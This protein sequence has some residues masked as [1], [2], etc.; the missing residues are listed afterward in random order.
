[1]YRFQ[2]TAPT[3]V[4]E[5]IALVGST[6]ALGQ[7]DITRCVRLQTDGDRYPLWWTELAIT[8]SPLKE[9]KIEYKYLRLNLYGEVEWE[10]G[11]HNRWIPQEYP[12]QF[13]AIIIVDDGDFGNPQPYPYGYFDKPIAKS[14]PTQ[15]TS[16]PKVMVV[17]S[18][19]AL[20]CSSWLLKGWTSRL[21]TV[22][23]DRYQ[24]V[25]CSFLGADVTSII[26]K[27]PRLIS[28][29]QPDIVIISL[30]LGNEGLAHCPR[31]QQQALR[32]RFETGLQELISMTRALGAYPILGG[33]YPHGEYN[34]EHY[35]VLQQTRAEMFTWGV[36]VIDWFPL[37]H[38]GI[39][40]W[41]KG[42]YFDPAHPN[43]EGHRLM[44]EA[45]NLSLFDLN[46]PQI[47]QQAIAPPISEITIPIEDENLSLSID[48]NQQRVRFTN[49]G[50][51][52]YTITPTWEALQ[53]K[54]RNR[55]ILKHSIYLEKSKGPTQW[56]FFSI[57]QEG[58][59]ETPLEI[60]PGN[61]LEYIEVSQFLKVNS[62]PIIFENEDL[63]IFKANTQLVGIIN[64]SYHTY[65]IHPM[66]QEVRSALKS[67]NEGVYQDPIDPHT[68]FRTMMIGAHGLE[69]RV[70]V[71]G[72]TVVYFQYQ[73]QLEQVQRVGIIPLGDRCAVRM[74]LYKLEYDGPAFPFDL[75]RTT[76][77]ADV[78]DIIAN[79][80]QDMWNPHFL[81]YNHDEKRIYH[82]RWSGLSFAHEVED[83]DNPLHD[84][85]PI[86]ARM[87]TRYSARSERFWYA[88]DKSDQLLFV[89]TG[90]FTPPK[91]TDLVS[92]LATK[93]QGKPFRLLLLSPQSSGDV[94]VLPNVYH[95]AL[96]FNPDRMY[97]NLEYWWDCTRLMAEIL[98][99]LG[100][101]T[102]NLFWCPPD[103]P[104][105]VSC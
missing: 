85:T 104:K 97:E 1:M 23:K 28:Q 76:D 69:S 4:G 63:I 72:R 24:F 42:I 95:Y 87:R 82:T 36:P 99:Q 6:P 25:N 47:Q 15:V 90:F 5:F 37:L 60:P 12:E 86:W 74:L 43:S 53:D 77:L 48:L 83:S 35:L 29:E 59:I 22:L 40:R 80:F 55:G 20:G 44:Y 81:H 102:K 100:I 38:D 19:V 34:L 46:Y 27:F 70:K 62:L 92:K 31:E 30:S 61:S 89:R 13:K 39:G 105:A 17:G 32:Q 54:L 57:Q 98:A 94:P 14:S 41:K 45:I 26:S 71:P 96:E 65:N 64:Q 91:V 8:T 93:C 50:T 73:C 3:K 21:E 101:S 75:T 33:V 67:M 9:E 2:V 16:A 103:V 51:Y 49:S 66:W 7:W 88:I 11:K 18:S 68:P 84:M 56:S 78:A 58:L 10:K 79:D 52:S